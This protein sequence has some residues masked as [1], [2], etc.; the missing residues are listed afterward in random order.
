VDIDLL[1]PFPDHLLVE[2][3]NFAFVVN[4]EYEWLPPFSFHYKMIGHEFA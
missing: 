3:P 2:R 1:S 4:V